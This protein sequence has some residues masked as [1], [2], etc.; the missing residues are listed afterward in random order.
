[1]ST[2]EE[3]TETDEDAW[4][5]WDAQEV[6]EWDAQEARPSPTSRSLDPPTRTREHAPSPPHGHI[7][8]ITRPVGT[9]IFPDEFLNKD[10]RYVVVV[11]CHGG[12]SAFDTPLP[13]KKRFTTAFDTVF[14][15]EL[16]M[17]TYA[18][19]SYALCK[20]L[21]ESPF[22]NKGDK[23][24]SRLET[25]MK[26]NAGGL[27]KA[28]VLNFKGM[29][30]RVTNMNI[31]TTGEYKTHSIDDGIFLFRS[32]DAAPRDEGVVKSKDIAPLLFQR[33][34]S[35]SVPTPTGSGFVTSLPSYTVSGRDSL[36]VQLSDLLEE[37][38]ALH[39]R[40]L[41][42]ENTTVVVVSCRVIPSRHMEDHRAFQSPAT[43]ASR[44]QPSTTSWSLAD[45]ASPKSV[46]GSGGGRRPNPKTKSKRKT[47]SKSKSKSKRQPKTK[48]KRKNKR[49]K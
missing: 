25:I 1:M 3:Q 47:K 11:V 18:G 12:C 30:D 5:A 43:S 10:M 35:V 49:N 15:S 45:D 7:G 6:P 24:V 41:T 13:K 4:A 34:G 44:D 26:R 38:G 42:P 48:R 31:F 46:H 39:K 17:L 22:P 33:T 29:S 20:E 36:G 21:F 19:N 27:E 2:A 14:T 37:G 9:P 23:L 8:P 16:G 40:G 32:G 28:N